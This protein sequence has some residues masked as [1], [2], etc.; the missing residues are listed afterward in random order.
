MLEELGDQ[1][2]TV[3]KMVET[4]QDLKE[5]HDMLKVVQGIDKNLQDLYVDDDF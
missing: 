5:E 4:L 3:L 2:G 1:T